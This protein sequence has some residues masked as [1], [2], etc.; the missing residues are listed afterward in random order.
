MALCLNKVDLPS[1]TTFVK[2]I[3]ASLPIHGAHAGTPTA[4]KEEM[5]FVRNHLRPSNRTILNLSGS[6]AKVRTSPPTG[7]WKCLSSAIMLQEPL[8]VFPVNDLSTLV[9]LPGLRK[10]AVEDPSLPSKGMIEC[11]KA[12]GGTVPT[13]WSVEEQSYTASSLH[14]S[15]DRD[16]SQSSLKGRKDHH[17]HHQL[18]DVLLMRPGSTVEDVFFFLKRLGALGG[19]FVRAEAFS[20]RPGGNKPKPIAKNEQIT[21][22][23]CVI[24]IM[25]NKRSAWQ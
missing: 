6:R 11:I 8:L 17:Q 3:Q 16:A 12:A 20:G 5:L 7:V 13:C 14:H 23:T 2:D 18:R 9:P 22:E 25:S 1:A 15:K 24:K 4:A 10:V 19:E 21:A